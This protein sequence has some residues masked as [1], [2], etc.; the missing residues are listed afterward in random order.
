[1]SLKVTDFS[2]S[3]KRKNRKI[4]AKIIFFI[5]VFYIIVNLILSFLIFPVRQNSISMQPILTENTVVMT[6]PLLKKVER[7]DIVLLKAQTSF[8][9]KFFQKMYRKFVLFFTAQQISPYEN[10]SQPCTKNH[11]RRVIGMPG[12][13]IYMKDYVLYIKPAGEK[14][15]LTEFELTEKKY[16]ISFY[17]PPSNWNSSLGVVGSFEEI[18]LK[19]NEYFLLGDNRR[20]CED[21]RLWGTLTNN[22]FVSK[23]LFCYFPFKNFKLL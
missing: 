3:L 11:L 13:T 20:S 18:Q 23:A 15:F 12:D 4:V 2:Y 9:E 16:T 21:S 10:N 22:D 5:L 8:E 7:G 14:H 6:S 1:M 17:T 19:D